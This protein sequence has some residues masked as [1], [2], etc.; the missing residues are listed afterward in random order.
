MDVVGG[1]EYLVSI[2]GTEKDRVNCPFY[3][4]IGSCR[5][6]DKCT[7]RHNKPTLSQT[8]RFIGLWNNPQI[9]NPRITQEALQEDFEDFFEDIF[10]ELAKFGEIEELNVCDNLGEHLLG[11]VYVKYRK[12][13]HAQKALQNLTGRFYDGAAVVAEYSPVTDFREA[14]CRQFENNEC[15]RA[16]FCNFMHLRKVGRDLQKYLF[17]RQTR[18]RS[19]SRSPKRNRRSR[20]KSPS[21]RDKPYDDRRKDDRPRDPRSRAPEDDLPYEETAQDRLERLQQELAARQ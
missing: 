20:S 3:F 2:Y 12:E 18:R 13:E 10:E 8:L 17:R 7:R 21:R 11:N 9:K 14:T 4:K 5:H 15:S 6:G 1:A 19:R 16:G